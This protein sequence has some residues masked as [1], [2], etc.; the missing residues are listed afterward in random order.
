ME[1]EEWKDIPN[2]DGLYQVSN[3][4]NVKS[5]SRTVLRNG[6]YPFLFKEK[7]LKNQKHSSG[8]FH[9]RLRKDNKPKTYLTHQL[10]S[11]AFLNHKP[12]GYELVIDHINNN[13][14]DNRLENLQIITQRENASKDVK[15]KTSKYTG[16]YWCKNKKKWKAAIRLNG[17]KKHLGTFI[18][19]EDANKIYKLKLKEII[20]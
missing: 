7:I 8:Y 11:M 1:K 9:V 6:K 16:V 15:N 5:L 2:Y 18:N 13:P 17:F 4:G 19:E 3:L 10:V 14:L 20:L 12:N